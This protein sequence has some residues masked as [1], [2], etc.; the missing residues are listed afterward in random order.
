[1]PIFEYQ[2]STCKSSFELLVRSDTTIACPECE[3]EKVVKR[4][5]LFA[6]HPGRR[7]DQLPDCHTGTRGCDLGRCGSGYCGVE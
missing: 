2:C 1:M 4:L 6:A 3:S 5:S 7:R